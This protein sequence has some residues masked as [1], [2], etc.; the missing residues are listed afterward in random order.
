M[1]SRVCGVRVMLVPQTTEMPIW[2]MAHQPPNREGWWNEH[3][4]SSFSQPIWMPVR[5]A[6]FW[7]SWQDLKLLPIQM[8]N[9]LRE[10]KTW[11]HQTWKEKSHWRYWKLQRRCLD[12]KSK[13][14][15]TSGELWS[16]SYQGYVIQRKRYLMSN[17]KIWSAPRNTFWWGVCKDTIG[18]Q[19]HA[20]C[21]GSACMWFDSTNS[22]LTRFGGSKTRSPSA[23]LQL[24][25]CW[26][27]CFWLC[28][29]VRTQQPSLGDL[30]SP[31]ILITS[32]S[33]RMILQVNHHFQSCTIFF[34]KG[35]SKWSGFHPVL[36]EPEL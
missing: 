33:P 1:H 29:Y 35:P 17:S 14:A 6:S 26:V 11:I 9:S 18:R 15:T 16:W 30:R 36:N 23:E 31:C 28:A 34:H 4:G 32:P 25:K 5:S 19:Q 8:S 3:F 21:F 2:G 12:L 10:W 13:R 27:P 24:W 7:T 22:C 20:R